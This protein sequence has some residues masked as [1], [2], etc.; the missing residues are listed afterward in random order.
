M[1]KYSAI[2]NHPERGRIEHDLASGTPVRIVQRK[3][4]LS[5]D[6][7]YRHL[8]KIPEQFKAEK[9]AERLGDAKDLEAL[10]TEEGEGLLKNLKWQ[11][12]RLLSVQDAAYE[13]A[14]IDLVG[15]IAR[16]IHHNIEMTGRYL[17]EFAKR[18]FQ[19]NISLLVTPEYMQLRA[20]LIQAL[21]PF[22]E[23]RQAVA[24]VLRKTETSFA[25]APNAAGRGAVPPMLEGRALEAADV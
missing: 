12:V 24:E 8:R 5:R 23:A 18:S 20:K 19:T 14:D 4:G 13:L 10:K 6:Q 16:H 25:D 7:C 2:E 1:P 9:V 3:Y 11:R 22:P 21:R 17:G 15:R